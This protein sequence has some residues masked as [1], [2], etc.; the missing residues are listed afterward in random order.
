MLSRA[1]GLVIRKPLFWRPNLTGKPAD[2][3]E[4][5]ETTKRHCLRRV[6]SKTEQL[7]LNI[8]HLRDIQHLGISGASKLLII[9]APGEI[10]TPGL[11][12]RRPVCYRSQG[13]VIHRGS[14]PLGV[15]YFR[16]LDAPKLLIYRDLPERYSTRKGGGNGAF[17][18]Q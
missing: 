15:E 2:A 4:P 5:I 14:T 17:D 3:P 9:G 10:R 12:V 7:K 18:C 11:L 1:M 16:R 6:T 8:Q 13:A